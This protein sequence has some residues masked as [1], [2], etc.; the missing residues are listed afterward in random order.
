SVLA[1]TL[2]VLARGDFSRTALGLASTTRATCGSMIRAIASA[3]AVAS[4]ATS[5]VGARLRANNS[6]AAGVVKIRPA[7]RTAPASAIATSQKSRCTSIPILRTITSLV[8]DN[9]SRG[10]GRSRQLRIRALS[11]PGH[12]RGRPTT[13]CGLSAH[14]NSGLPSQRSHRAP[15]RDRRR[16]YASARTNELTRIFMALQPQALAHRRRRPTTHHPRPAGPQA[17]QLIWPNVCQVA[18]TEGPALRGFLLVWEAAGGGR[19]RDARS[20]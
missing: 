17:G 10:G 16:R 7:A 20:H 4:I 1:S 14:R 11:T 15:A 5:S 19:V 12:S 8:V 2:S 3:L 13:N 9:G 6:S 18:S